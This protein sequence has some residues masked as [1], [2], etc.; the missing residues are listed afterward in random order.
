MDEHHDDVSEARN[1]DFIV[2]QV[3]FRGCFY[4]CLFIV[5]M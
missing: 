5:I 1:D 2:F 3:D 4:F